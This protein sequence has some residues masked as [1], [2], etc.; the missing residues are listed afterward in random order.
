MQQIAPKLWIGSN[1][2]FLELD[3]FGT[4]WAIVHACKEP[5][6]RAALGYTGRAA[7]SDDPEYMVAVRGKRMMLNLIDV[8]DPKFVHKAMIDAALEHIKTHLDKGSFVLCHCN[9]GASRSPTIGMLHL[10]P[11][12]PDDFD[13]AETAYKLICPSYAPARGMREFAKANWAQYRASAEAAAVRSDNSLIGRLTR[14]KQDVKETA[15]IQD[16][17]DE[18]VRLRKFRDSVGAMVENCKAFSD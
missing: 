2:D 14:H 10:A 1:A 16:A 18:I 6:H 12:L 11:T 9:Q 3:Q 15:L 4:D 5:H 8:D 13:E 7:P 17:I